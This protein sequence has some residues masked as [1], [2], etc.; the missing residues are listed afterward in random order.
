MH[1]LE[2]LNTVTSFCS[3]FHFA[4]LCVC[5]FLL[6]FSF[7]PFA[8]LCPNI[9]FIAFCISSLGFQFCIFS[10]SFLFW[11]QLPPNGFQDHYCLGLGVG[12]AE[13]EGTHMCFCFCNIVSV[14]L[15]GYPKP[16]PLGNWRGE[17]QNWGTGWEG[18]LSFH[19]KPFL[20]F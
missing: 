7:I 2:L 17:L 16:V 6:S 9:P 19:C 12:G 14:S 15:E 1:F 13:R 4:A 5:L 10:C 18:S 11:S 3:S 8:D 20:C